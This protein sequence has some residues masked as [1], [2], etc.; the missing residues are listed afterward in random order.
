M[1]K[2]TFF[3][4]L[5]FLLLDVC[6]SV[7]G[8]GS[9]SG[10]LTFSGSMWVR[11]KSTDNSIRES[12]GNLD[13]LGSD[14][15]ITYALDI[16]NNSRTDYNSSNAYARID[17]GEKILYKK[18]SVGAGDSAH[19]FISYK[20]LQNMNLTNLG[21]GTHKMDFYLNDTL[22]YTMQ[23]KLYRGSSG[24]ASTSG[25]LT[26]SGSMWVRSKSTD[27]SIRE[28]DGNLDDLSSD[29]YITYALD[30]RN[31]SRTEYNSSNAYARIDNGEK[32]LY[33][34]FSVGAGDSAHRFISYK[35]LQNMNLT[36]LGPG[37][38][39]MD[40][41]LND[42]LVY[43]TQFKLYRGSSGQGSTS[44]QLKYN[45]DLQVH[46]ISTMNYV[47]MSNGRLDEL[48]PD[49]YISFVVGI[50][51][52]SQT[53]FK[54]SNAYSRID[55]GGKISWGDLTVRFGVKN[56]LIISPWI[57][58]NLAPGTH[59]LDFYM[60]D[61]LVYSKHFHLIRAWK[62]LMSYPSQSQ[63]ESVRGKARS[64]YITYYPQFPGVTGL[65]EYSI[66]FWIDDLDDDTYFS[67]MDWDMDVSSLQ[68]KYK[69]V[70]NDYNTPGG[71]Y[72]GFQTWEN[73][74]TGVIMSV[75]DVFC[76]DDY[77]NVTVYRAKELYPEVKE[78][79]ARSSSSEGSFQQFIRE[80]DWKEKHPYRMLMQ[81]S[82][83]EKTGNTVLTMWVCDLVN[84][85]WEKLAAF[86][87]GYYSP[88]MKTNNLGG[89]LENYG[90]SYAGSVRNVSFSNIRG[91]DYK[92]GRWVAAKSVTFYINNS[93]HDLNYMG[94]YN[95]GSD[96]ST[97]WIITSGVNG[98]CLGPKAGSTF[99][100]KY[101]SAESPY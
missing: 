24:Q 42:T 6:P 56:T 25:Q 12:D 3:L 101:A 10:Q 7:Y 41:Y 87:L 69:Y 80:Y 38:H 17:N 52:D 66:D 21:P 31:N 13:D 50:T 71:V 73:G 59:K 94:S 18:F 8:Q 98:L 55:D 68:S 30:I 43:T 16:R 22:V 14:E 2:K 32:I 61:T 48:G 26:F 1:K 60:N 74:R 88:Y 46:N 93:V 57:M 34:K 70:Y 91:T 28:S 35:T 39:K 51:N 65:N 53:E 20:T 54:T 95:F 75:W 96:D 78:G 84:M 58:Q 27:S 62:S 11:S 85:K 49:E 5:L 99:S 97:F 9:T 45:G 76:K 36:N 15:Y 79:I 47:R 33:K 19:R 37:T 4:L 23:F 77:G 72:C 29:E 40:F 81:Q 90:V 92:T 100:V 63:I 89:F 86:D 64:P 83:S 82:V 44:S 67:T